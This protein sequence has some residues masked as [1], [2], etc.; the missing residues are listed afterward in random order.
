M[1]GLQI[2]TKQVPVLDSREVA[3]MV[4]IQHKNLIRNIDHYIEVLGKGS[5]LSSSNFFIERT[6]IRLAMVRK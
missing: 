6:T 3:E 2:F 4:G 1:N 5:K